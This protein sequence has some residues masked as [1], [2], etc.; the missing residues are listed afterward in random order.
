[1][2]RLDFSGRVALVTGAGRGLGAA[3]AEALARAGA[4]VMVNDVAVSRDG[5][6][7][8]QALADRLA[9]EGLRVAADTGS[10]G[11]EDAATAAVERTVE[12]FG[13][14]DILI[15]NAG[16]GAMGPL[17]DQSSETFR[18]VLDVHL[19]G[20]FWTM[21]AAIPHMR[22]QGHGRIVNSSSAVGAFGAPDFALYSAAK[23]ALIGL[24]RSCAQEHLDVD[25]RI[26]AVAPVAQTAMGKGFFDLNPMLDG[27]IY[28]VSHVTPMVTYLCHADCTLTGA[29]MTAGAGRYA[30]IWS[31]TAAGVFRPGVEDGDFGALLPA[32]SNREGEIEP[33]NAL[34]EFIL[35]NS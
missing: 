30:R 10:M 12:R 22:A 24:T 16:V 28:D 32:L 33:W 20:S 34:D 3:Y 9:G 6:P 14:I 35:V 21:R 31:S 26:N 18:R 1:M 11:A 5:T 27:S 7:R 25:L 4:D 15:N 8:A 13:R 17:H 19:M 2:S 29:L 23:A